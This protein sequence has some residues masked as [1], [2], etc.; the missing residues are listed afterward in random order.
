MKMIRTV[1]HGSPSVVKAAVFLLLTFVTAGWSG[2]EVTGPASIRI[3]SFSGLQPAAGLPPGWKPL[4]FKKIKRHTRYRLVVD[5]GKTVIEARSEASA[6][7]LVRPVEIDPHDFP[8]IQ[9]HWKVPR[10]LAGSRVTS[11]AGDD[12]A[13]R[14]YV[15]FAFEPERAGFWKRLAH[16]AASSAAG[17]QLP[18]S[19]LIYVWSANDPQ[20]LIVSNPYSADI[21]MVVVRSGKSMAAKWVT[22]RRNILEDYRRAYG[23][24]PGMISAIAIMTD[25]DNTGDSTVAYYGDIV[26]LA[27]RKAE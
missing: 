1:K 3:G 27:P 7:G 24:E 23:R 14:I 4:T 25:T 18:G 15:T 19:A 11:K 20:G 8:V 16:K 17:K 21:K 10:P 2:A 5:E 13:A 9:W 6:S 26:L 12:Y 22:E